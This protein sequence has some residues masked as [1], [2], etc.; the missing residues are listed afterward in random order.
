MLELQKWGKH[1]N[2][3]GSSEVIGNTQECNFYRSSSYKVP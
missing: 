2:S 1:K 3:Y